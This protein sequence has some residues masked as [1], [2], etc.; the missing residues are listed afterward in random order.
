MNNIFKTLTGAIGQAVRTAPT[1][2]NQAKKSYE[3]FMMD[4]PTNIEYAQTKVRQA[5]SPKAFVPT[6]AEMQ[7]RQ[8]A[9]EQKPKNQTPMGQ[10]Q[11]K[12]ANEDIYMEPRANK[13]GSAEM[14]PYRVYPN[15]PKLSALKQATLNSMNLRPAMNRYLSTVP[16][17]RAPIISEGALGYALGG[18]G[19]P[20][21]KGGT[22]ETDFGPISNPAIVLDRTLGVMPQ[23]QDAIDVLSH[24][25]V[26][27]V[28]R[29]D[30]VKTGMAKL[31]LNI[32]RNSPILP[33]AMQYF[34]DGRLPPNPEELFATLG[35]QFGQFALNIPEIR[36][37]YRNI[38]AQPTQG[39]YRQ[40]GNLGSVRNLIPNVQ[41]VE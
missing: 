16:V 35:Q 20:Q 29:T 2:L 12:F 8:K 37:Y 3:G 17:Q 22:W 28:P 4:L 36:E 39:G 19:E 34:A 25:Y 31:L 7:Q 40:P 11:D 32:P 15:D 21:E 6:Y 18:Q 13:S 38:Y 24:E 9:W 41:A 30:T 33:A 23:R 5:I 14:E 1:A 10:L 27:T 26:H